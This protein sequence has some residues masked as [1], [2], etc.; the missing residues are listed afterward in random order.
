MV[1]NENNS[2]INSFTKGMNSDGAYD[3]LDSGQYVFGY[4]V[5]TTKNQFLG[6]KDDYASVHE[7]IITP[8]PEGLHLDSIEENI[9]KI[10]AV[11]SVDQMGIIITSVDTTMRVYRLYLDERNNEI[12]D[13]AKLW[14]GTVWKEGKVPEQVSAVL[15]KEL[16]NVT[17]LYIADGVHPIICMRVDEEGSSKLTTAQLDDLINNRIVPTERIFIDEVISGRLLTSQVQYTYRYYN[18]YG[19]TTQLAPLTNKI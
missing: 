13:F 17:K 14:E 12:T 2:F 10:L 19:N 1:T 9:G 4:N 6:D 3:Q 8:V 16:D 5:R 11:K 18:K 15:Y 7:G